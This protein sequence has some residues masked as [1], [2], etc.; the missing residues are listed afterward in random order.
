MAR[1]GEGGELLKCSFCGKSQ[2]QVK[3]LI[4]GPTVY[5]C[6]ECIELCNEIIEEELSSSEEINFTELPKPAEIKT[7]LDDYVVG[8]EEAKRKLSVAVYNHYKRIRS[9]EIQRD[10][11]LQKSN[12]ILIGPTGSGKTLLA[13]TLARQLNVPFAIADATSLTEAGYVGE[14]VENILLKLLQA[15]DYDVNRAQQGI[16]YIDEI[17]KVSR[18]AENPSITRD[19]SGE[20]VQQALLKILEGTVA[21]VPPQGGR[22]HPHQE[23]IQLDTT[24]VLFICG[25][26]FGGLEDIIGNRIG[27]RGVGFGAELASKNDRRPSELIVNVLPEDLLKYGLIPE[28]IGRLP[29]TAT[30]EDLDKEALIRILTEPKNALTKQYA[31]M[32]EMDDVELVFTPDSLE[33]I[34]EQA[35]KRSTGAR[36]LRA[37]MEEVLLNTMYDLP[38]RDDIER[39]MIDRDVVEKK[40]NPTLVPN[41]RAEEPTERSA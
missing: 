22:K 36:G 39:V 27:K 5:I 20:G 30:V 16:I 24:N 31:R 9:G 26:A 3:K 25:G 38:S 8:Q 41:E 11:E 14:D 1:L 4:A 28:F 18:K 13:Q 10:V 29:V 37:I 35:L 33:A 40:V 2:K 12:I 17:D 15:A 6:D 7:Y 21:S 34:S 32:F 19:V 23:F